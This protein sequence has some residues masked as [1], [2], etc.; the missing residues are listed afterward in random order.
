MYGKIKRTWTVKNGKPAVNDPLKKEYILPI[1]HY[2]LWLLD[3]LLDLWAC[4]Y[5]PHLEQM[6]SKAYQYDEERLRP[7]QSKIHAL[8]EQ[9][10]VDTQEP[11]AKNLVGDLVLSGEQW[12]RLSQLIQMGQRQLEYQPHLSI[13]SKH[14]LLYAYQQLHAKLTK[15]KGTEPR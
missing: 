1:T 8:V 2:D 3:G 7:V 5:M 11:P 9:Y 15:L 6:D 10:P 4:Y 14:Y 13:E 12:N